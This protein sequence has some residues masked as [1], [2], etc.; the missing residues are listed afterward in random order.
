MKRDAVFRRVKVHLH[1][2]LRD[3]FKIVR[4]GGHIYPILVDFACGNAV[5]QAESSIWLE[6]PPSILKDD[7]LSIVDCPGIQYLYADHI[8]NI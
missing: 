4:V 3:S 6:G 2:V 8:Y 5:S 1:E 7:A